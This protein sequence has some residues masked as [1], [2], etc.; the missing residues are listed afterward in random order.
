[1]DDLWL[2]QNYFILCVF[3]GLQLFGGRGRG[4]KVLTET[5]ED[6]LLWKLLYFITS[7]FVG[8]IFESIKVPFFV[9][10]HFENS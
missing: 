10:P 3:A 2:H 6:H 5:K 9:F 7:K 8:R 4:E 1:M